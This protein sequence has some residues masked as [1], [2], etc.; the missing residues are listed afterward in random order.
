MIAT[1]KLLSVNTLYNGRELELAITLNLC[2]FLPE[3]AIH[4]PI[5]STP[6]P[7]PWHMPNICSINSL[8]EH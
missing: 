7:L 4:A 3:S 2:A 6:D 8:I 5:A 1:E